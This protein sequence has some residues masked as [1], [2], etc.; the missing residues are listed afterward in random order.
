MEVAV[1][2]GRAVVVDHDV[3]TLHIDTT[4]E[5]IGCN[6]DTLLERLE[7]RVAGDTTRYDELIYVYLL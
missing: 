7:R 3:N 1:S 4:A 5:D 2:V 6:K